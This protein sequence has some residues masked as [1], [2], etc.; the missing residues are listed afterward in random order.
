MNL[1]V[2]HETP[3]NATVRRDFGF[4]SALF[5]RQFIIG[6]LLRWA[7]KPIARGDSWISA[8]SVLSPS[9]EAFE[10]SLCFVFWASFTSSYLQGAKDL[11]SKV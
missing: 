9:S 8:I 6:V 1:H 11:Q 3:L 4:S 5:L 10:E 2:V 7:I